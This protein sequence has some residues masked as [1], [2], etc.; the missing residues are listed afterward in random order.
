[1]KLT[2][3]NNELDPRQFVQIEY[4]CLLKEWM[5]VREQH[6]RARLY[7]DAV[8]VQNDVTPKTKQE[9]LQLLN[10]DGDYCVLCHAGDP[11]TIAVA[12][13]VISI[14]VSLYAYSN[15]P[16]PPSTVEGSSNNS[17]SE[18]K[19]KYNVNGR[20]PDIYGKVLSIPTLIAPLY[21]YYKDNVQTE[22]CL[23]SVGNG[24]FDIPESTMLEGETPINTINGAS[25]SVYEPNDILISGAPQIQIGEAFTDYPIVTKQ[26]SAIDG[27]QTLIPPNNGQMAYKGLAFE[28]GN[29]INLAAIKQGV[30][31]TWAFSPF[32]NVWTK[33]S[34]DLFGNFTTFFDN[35]EQLIIEGANYGAVADQPLSG[36]TN[37]TAAG[38][39][40]IASAVNI[41]NPDKYKRIR[42]N[43]LNITDPANGALNLAGDY[44]VSSI[45]KSGSYAYEIQLVNFSEVN[46]NFS[47]ITADGVAVSSTVLT[48]NTDNIDLS[49]TYTIATVS[50]NQIKLVNP[51]VINSDWNRLSEL[52]AQ[53]KAD[54]YNRHILFKGSANNFIG[55]YYAGNENSTGM[56]LNFLAQSGIFEGDSARQVAIEVQYQQVVGGVPTGTIYKIGQV[57]QGKANNRNAIGMTIKENLPF[58]GKYRFRVMRINDNGNGQNLIDDVVF[59]SAYSFYQS[60]KMWYAYDTIVRLK[61]L[62]IGSGTNASEFK[63]IATR[64]LYSYAIGAQSF[65]RIPTNNAADIVVNMA[66]DDN[67]GRM[68]LTEVDVLSFYDRA[69]DIAAYFG[70]ALA[71]EFNYTFDNKNSSYQ[72][73]VAMVADAVF[74]TAR[75]ENG[76]HYF[77]FERETPNSIVLF[78]HRNMKPESLTVTESFGIAGDY[79]GVEFKWRDATD[80]YAE[81]VIKLPDENR[82]NYKSIEAP[83]IT[84]KVQAHLQAWRA[85]NKI[86][87]N[88]KTIEFT[89]YGET[90]LVT[91]KDRI[92]VVDSTLPMV[93]AGQIDGQLNKVV[94]IDYPVQ[95]EAGINYVMHIQLKTGMVDVIDIVS[96]LSDY[97]IEL[98]RIPLVPL[99]VGGVAHATFSITRADDANH[100]AYLIEDKSPNSMIESGISARQYDSRYYAND[101]DFINNLI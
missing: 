21:R 48:K 19:N 61:R 96:Q 11:L 93:A 50:N 27:K 81:S 55:W 12:S 63:M 57:M 40:T 74:C 99:V 70:T 28:N 22:E 67:I 13:L 73:M 86:R 34:Q 25:V 41:N 56:L 16:K 39:L 92:A 69:D 97:E 10:A 76:L 87:Y 77:S 9:A 38:L 18:R 85:W 26:I 24:Y 91:R 32:S 95:L 101:T 2:I 20:V 65:D 47:L 49:G 80:N 17:L 72:E 53:Q 90:D 31:Y 84:N 46:V 5:Q 44:E 82:D 75:R 3:F 15:M 98:Q 43:A 79:D 6:P 66:I 36:T 37:V 52:T 8:C 83:G 35:G 60:E 42:I 54:L 1:M 62:A 58:A 68:D 88:R 94:M 100:E 14:G 89:G 33:L 59:E 23:M 7:K 29:E 51:E 78:N 4:E 30:T 64:K 71:R 45:T